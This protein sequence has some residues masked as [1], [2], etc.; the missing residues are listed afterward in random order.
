MKLP[1]GVR[2]WLSIAQD[3]QDIRRGIED[4]LDFHLESRIDDLMR[5]GLP[6]AAARAQALQEFGDMQQ[7]RDELGAIDVRGA[8]RKRRAQWWSDIGQDVKFA[9]RGV[10]RQPGFAAVI[11][12]TLGLGLGV[13]AAT[14]DLVD[15]LLFRPPPHVQQPERVQRIYFQQTFDRPGLVGGAG[16][17]AQPSSMYVDFATLR[18]HGRNLEIAAYMGTESTIGRGEQAEKIRMGVASGNFF[19]LLG[20]RPHLGRF[21]TPAEDAPPHGEALAVLDHGYWQRRFGGSATAIG[22]TLLIGQK[23]FTIVGVAPP[24]FTGVEARTMDVWVPVSVIAEEWDGADWTTS[25][26]MSWLSMVGRL[27]PGGTAEAAAAELTGLWRPL[28]PQRLRDDA[29]AVVMGPIQKARGPAPS[30]EKQNGAVAGWL[31]G[32]SFLVLLVACANVANLLLTRG[33]RQRRETGVRLALGI[34]K[35]RLLR[36]FIVESLLLCSLAAVAAFALSRL[37]GGMLR[38]LLLP[39]MAWSSSPLD[40]RLILF[41]L[42]GLLFTTVAVVLVPAWQT[43]RESILPAL[44]AG[45][46]EGQA[47]SRVRTSLLFIQATASVVLLI[48]ASL[49]VRSFNNVSNTHLGFDPDQVVFADIDLNVLGWDRPRRLDFFARARDHIT[50]LPGVEGAAIASSVPFWSAMMPDVYADGHDTIRVPGVGGPLNVNVTPEYFAVMGTRVVRGRGFTASDNESA[51]KV[52]IINETMARVLWPRQ[53]A[54]GKCLYVGEHKENPPCATI[55]GIA[56]DTRPMQIKNDPVMSFYLPLA[57]ASRGFINLLVRTRG[58]ARDAVP[59]VQRSLQTFAPNLP[60]ADA[61]SLQDLIDPQTRSWKLGASLFA[62]F[63]LL[64]LLVAAVGLYSMLSHVVAN[65]TRE[66]G[67]RMALG[68]RAGDVL[69]MIV[70]D[71]MTVAVAGMLA[72]VGLAYFAALRVTPLLYEVS[73]RDPLSYIAAGG[74]LLLVAFVAVL[75]PARRAT[76]IDPA[77][78]L[79]AD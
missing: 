7:A 49:F 56:E 53:E 3:A 58:D 20:V 63:G 43:L 26:S 15:R 29:A 68:A 4:E 71:G 35:F 57:Q 40:V 32:V 2:R 38:T 54:L 45:A 50:R 1:Q 9:W 13:N 46:R 48:G 12:L 37:S 70:R 44:R 78:A 64:A 11:V 8:E 21:Y 39:K 72:G 62:V 10:R 73:A 17:V 77:S 60:Y 33:L 25:R 75:I 27:R 76:G 31:A 6:R 67:V 59:A 34:G 18:E 74:V 51:S 69:R 14:F 16:V 30:E 28:L 52:A 61:R 66:V 42:L 65:R 5:S 79:K 47:R 24:G 41:L 23:T 36:Q 55:V 19:S 22:Q